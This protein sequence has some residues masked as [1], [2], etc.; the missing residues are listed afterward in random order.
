M[1][2][3]FNRSI[4]QQPTDPSVLGSGAMFDSIANFYDNVNTL[5]T[6]A[7]DKQ[8]RDALL[9]MSLTP[10]TLGPIRMLDIACGTCEVMAAAAS[11]YTIEKI[12]GVDPSRNMLSRCAAK[13]PPQATIVISN[14]EDFAT[15]E[16]FTVS[17][18]A[19]GIRNMKDRE[20][21]VCNIWNL[22]EEGGRLGVLEVSYQPAFS[23]L[24]HDSTVLRVLISYFIHY[25]V[26]IIGFVVNGFKNFAEYKHLVDSIETFP[27]PADF[28]TEVLNYK[29]SGWRHIK[30]TERNFG[31]IKIDVFEKIKLED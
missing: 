10:P 1:T 20:K 30:T 13:L 29:C 11:S 22:L 14:A 15:T 12:V 4:T 24:Q 8:W 17:T 31:T 21:A 25:V 9:E 2:I 18:I 16:K 28:V 23:L 19:F 27:S 7:Q 26:P 6:F 5:F 3:L